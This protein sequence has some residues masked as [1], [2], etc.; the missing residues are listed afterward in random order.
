MLL[1]LF[2]LSGCFKIL[3]GFQIS[4]EFYLNKSLKDKKEKDLFSLTISLG[5]LAQ[6]PPVATPLP[7]FSLPAWAK[8]Q[9]GPISTPP[10]LPSALAGRETDQPSPAARMPSTRLDT[11]YLDPLPSFADDLGPLVGPVP[12][13]VSKWDSM[14]SS[15]RPHGFSVLA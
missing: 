8:Q 14:S 2:C 6:S 9:A 1:H 7:L 3:S 11:N 12:Y 13:L 5:Y 4:F 10:S 15:S